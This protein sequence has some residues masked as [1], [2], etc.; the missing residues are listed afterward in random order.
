MNQVFR[1][2]V[3]ESVLFDLL[4]II[5]LKTDK[6]YL[7]DMNSYKK[8]MFHKMNEDFVEKMKE[9]YHASKMFYAT[10]EMTYNSFVNIIRHICKSANIGYT[11][12]IKY[13]ESNYNINY[14]IYYK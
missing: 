8:F 4:E 5:S 6:Y 10:R 14:L 9:Y 13:N 1:K 2:P 11:S 3:P 12:Q 7:I